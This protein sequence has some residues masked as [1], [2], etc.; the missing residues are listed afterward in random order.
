[1][2]C[3]LNASY[4]HS[5]LIFKCCCFLF[6]ACIEHQMMSRNECFFCKANIEQ[7]V[8]AKPDAGVKL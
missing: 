6:R 7:V 5:I 3:S 8:D 1:M 2:D 4:F